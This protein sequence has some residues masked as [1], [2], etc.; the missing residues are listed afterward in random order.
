MEI[1][2]TD[3]V[4]VEVLVD[5]VDPVLGRLAHAWINPEADADPYSPRLAT[6]ELSLPLVEDLLQDL[7]LAAAA[8]RLVVV[9]PAV[10]VVQLVPL[11]PHQSEWGDPLPPGSLEE[12]DSFPV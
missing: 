7:D 8:A 1:S 4:D 11:T 9:P 2:P 5:A 12:V 10:E 6:E 3:P